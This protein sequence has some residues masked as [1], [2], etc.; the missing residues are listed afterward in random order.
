MHIV[1]GRRVLPALFTAL[2]AALAA[3]GAI[4][5]PTPAAPAA[6]SHGYDQPQKNILDVLH[7][8]SPPT[9]YVSP[10][11]QAALLVAWQD[12]PP[13]SRVAA[14]FLKLAG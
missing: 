6:A 12:F 13:M 7:A 5:A 8:P 10:T 4:A 3:A 9:P 11:R 2:S 14:P 1:L